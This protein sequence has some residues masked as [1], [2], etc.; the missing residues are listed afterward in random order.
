MILFCKMNYVII[1]ILSSELEVD[2]KEFVMHK[3]Y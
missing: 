1:L 3:M 2:N